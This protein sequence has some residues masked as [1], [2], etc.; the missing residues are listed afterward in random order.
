MILTTIDMELALQITLILTAVGHFACALAVLFYH[1][2]L[3]PKTGPSIAMRF[4]ITL[5]S[6]AIGLV[7]FVFIKRDPVDA[8]HLETITDQ[9]SLKHDKN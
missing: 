6:G 1:M 8:E 7:Y 9:P 4:L 3:P 5:A 2:K